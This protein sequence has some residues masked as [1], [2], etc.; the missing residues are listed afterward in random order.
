MERN[1]WKLATIGMALVGTTALGTGLTTSY[2]MRTPATADAQEIAVSPRVSTAP[3]ALVAQLIITRVKL[4][5]APRIPRVYVPD[6][7]SAETAA[8]ELLQSA[9]VTSMAA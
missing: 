7:K 1:P 4:R 5:P 9:Q 3:R 8:V 2:I 6:G